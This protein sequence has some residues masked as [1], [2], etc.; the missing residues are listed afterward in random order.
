V[1][2]HQ[3]QVYPVEFD[4]VHFGGGRHPEH[5]VERN[6]R[7]GAVA[8][9]HKAGPRGVVEFGIIVVRHGKVNYEL[10]MTDYE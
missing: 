6:G 5:G 4:A 7:L 3:A 8:F 2:T 1:R 10:R 9:A